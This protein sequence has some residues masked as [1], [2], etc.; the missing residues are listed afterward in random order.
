MTDGST[1]A[2]VVKPFQNHTVCYTS[3][4]GGFS[5]DMLKGLAELA[6]I[7]II[8]QNSQDCTYVSDNMFAVHTLNGGKRVFNVPPQF[9]TKVT[10]LFTGKEFPIQNGKFEYSME[11]ISTSLFLM[12]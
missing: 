6:G 4:P 5:T 12:E 2:L 1:P 10:E 8:N 7:T 3:I 11:P 9:T